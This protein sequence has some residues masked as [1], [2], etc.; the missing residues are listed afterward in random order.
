MG[1]G[2]KTHLSEHKCVHLADVDECRTLPD[3]CRGDMRCVNQNGGYLCL[4]R[5]L[6]SQPY[7]PEP[8]QVQQQQPE[9]TYQGGGGGGGGG[10]AGTGTGTGIGTSA[11]QP[12][13]YVPAPPRSGE[14][15]YPQVGY[16]VPCILGYVLADDGTCNGECFYFVLCVRSCCHLFVCQVF[17]NSCVL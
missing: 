12:N 4:P 14:P 10:G 15:S 7:G 1:G 2:A 11:S 17:F 13:S 3:P 8:P 9:S 5:G 6:Y 16:T